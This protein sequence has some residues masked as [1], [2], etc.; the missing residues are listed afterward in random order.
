LS[1]RP[2]QQELSKLAQIGLVKLRNDGNR[3][4]YGANIEHPLFPEIR[5]IVEKTSGVPALLE[6]ALGLRPFDR[7][8]QCRYIDLRLR[9]GNERIDGC[10]SLSDQVIAPLLDSAKAQR[11]DSLAV[12]PRSEGGSNRLSIDLAHQLADVLFL[13]VEPSMRG[14]ATCK[15]DR[16]AQVVR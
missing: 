15:L 16:I 5:G 7:A 14:D 9:L 1:I 12:P 11:S 6:T 4:Y 2:V 13:P 8:R 10:G 3:I